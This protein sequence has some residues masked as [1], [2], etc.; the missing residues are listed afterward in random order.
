MLR[1]RES[2]HRPIMTSVCGARVRLAA[3]AETGELVAGRQLWPC[4]ALGTTHMTAG[5]G[6]AFVRGCFVNTESSKLS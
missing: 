6:T 1:R 2:F 3:A 5:G 4:A